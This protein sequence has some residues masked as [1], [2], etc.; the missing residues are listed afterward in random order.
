MTMTST[1][2]PLTDNPEEP[3]E[4][5]PASVLVFNSGDPSGAGGLN[6]DGLAIAA[7]GAHCLGIF[8]GSYIKDTA[9]VLGHMAFD[10]EAVSDQARHIL[11]DVS[12]QVIK[13]GFCGSAENIGVIAGI[14]TDYS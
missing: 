5:V 12:I 10:E 3:E 1:Q 13:V 7:V 4:G 8:C 11:E 6:G 14:C 9:E 2:E